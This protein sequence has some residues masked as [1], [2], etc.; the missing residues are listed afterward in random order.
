VFIKLL[1]LKYLFVF[2]CINS[3]NQLWVLVLYFFHFLSGLEH[4]HKVS[5]FFPGHCFI[6]NV[7]EG[8]LQLTFIIMIWLLFGRLPIHVFKVIIDFYFDTRVIVKVFVTWTWNDALPKRCVGS[9]IVH[10]LAQW[11][12]FIIIIRI[13]LLNSLCKWWLVYRS[14]RNHVI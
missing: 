9:L 5:V 12:L 3:S 6:M 2:K 1:K 8:Q 11:L 4:T 14:S 10:W 13:I 7:V